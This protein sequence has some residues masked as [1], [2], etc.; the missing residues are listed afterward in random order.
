MYIN[1]LS[2]G[3]LLRKISMQKSILILFNFNL[4]TDYGL[5][6][7]TTNQYDNVIV[8]QLFRYSPMYYMYEYLTKFNLVFT[9]F[10]WIKI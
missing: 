9:Y 6:K 3:G 8:E 7:N 10:S 2:R 1:G 4:A 5:S